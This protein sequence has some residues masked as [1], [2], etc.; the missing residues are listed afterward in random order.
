MHTTRTKRWLTLYVVSVTLTG[1]ALLGRA[2]PSV[3]ENPLV[4]AGLLLLASALSALKI[5]V[6]L[7]R[8]WAT[9]ST[10]F[11]ALFVAMLTMGVAPA[12]VIA[13]VSG[14]VQSAFH[15]KTR[16]P[17]WRHLFNSMMLVLSVAAAGAAFGL[18]GGQLGGLGLRIAISPLIGATAAY[19]L[20]NS[21]IV[22][23]A[24]AVSTGQPV[25]RCWHDNFLWTAPGYFLTAA[26]VY[27]AALVAREDDS[28]PIVLFVLLPVAF[29]YHAYKVYFGRLHDEQKRVQAMADLHASAREDLASEKERLAVT[30]RSIG[31]G[32]ITTD[33][34]GRVTMLNVVA[35][36]LTGRTQDRAIGR[37]IDDVLC[38]WDPEGTTVQ[39][40]P[41]LR[42]LE[43]GRMP[44]SEANA[45]LI[46]PDGAR[47]S[48]ILTGRADVRRRG[49]EGRRGDGRPRHHRERAADPGT[50]PRQQA[51]VARRAGRRHRPRLQQR[52]DGR[53]R[54]HRPGAQRRNAVARDGDLA[55]RS[56]TR[57]PAGTDPHPPAAD[58]LARR[59]SR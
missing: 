4:F 30:L 58:L 25:W 10:S 33:L 52:A 11:A 46:A 59:R 24:V 3:R 1:L 18:L 13:A 40:V 8:G 43:T 28:W 15:S 12:L 32:V 21:L 51:G 37:A 26:V 50:G 44:E 19:F 36:Q 49:P 22:S 42:I 34:Q 39:E 54:Q 57:L 20:A 5:H 2:L 45:S 48:V 6:P 31:D 14:W 55:R 27:L 16:S 53:G 38:L 29:I 7:A 47:L 23:T 35:E 17:L 41:V 56:R 9:M